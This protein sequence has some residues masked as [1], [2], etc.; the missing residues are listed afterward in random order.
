MSTVQE[1]SA[2][3]ALPLVAAQFKPAIPIRARYDNWIG[4]K[5]AAPARGQYFTNPSPVTG[6]PLC[7]VARSTHEDVDK[8]LAKA[9]DQIKGASSDHAT[10]LNSQVGRIDTALAEA[11]DRL[12]SS[13]DDIKDLAAALEDAR[14]RWTTEAAE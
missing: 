2:V 7:E 1:G 13:L 14:G 3:A 9:L 5:P 11:V 4:G 6:Q 12:A 8:A 10:E